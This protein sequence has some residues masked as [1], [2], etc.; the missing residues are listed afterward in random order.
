M[1]RIDLQLTIFSKVDLSIARN[2]EQG[3]LLVLRI[4]PRKDH[5]IGTKCAAEVAGF[6]SLKRTVGS[7]EQHIEW[8]FRGIYRH[9][10]IEK[11]IVESAM[12]V[13]IQ[14]PDVCKRSTCA[15]QD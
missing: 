14:I 7:K 2:R 15:P 5:G 3:D 6:D 13:C 4:Y 12:D 11:R 10:N 9:K 1:R 8:I